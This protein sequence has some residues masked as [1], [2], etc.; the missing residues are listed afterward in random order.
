M[1]GGGTGRLM[2]GPAVLFR[3]MNAT[4]SL[5]GCGG[6]TSSPSLQDCAVGEAVPKAHGPEREQRGGVP[7][8]ASWQSPE[9]KKGGRGGRNNLKSRKGSRSELGTWGWR[10]LPRR[11]APRR[12]GSEEAAWVS[13]GGAAS[14]HLF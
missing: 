6:P 8:P 10:G 4:V 13:R 7:R 12:Q 11:E 5:L 3:A 14:G 9:V 2:A 1:G